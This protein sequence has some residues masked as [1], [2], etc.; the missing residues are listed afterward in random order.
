MA[1]HPYMGVI[2]IA[3]CSPLVSSLDV[4]EVLWLVDYTWFLVSIPSEIS[5]RRWVPVTTM[6][7]CLVFPLWRR[8][9]GMSS[10][11]FGSL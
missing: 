3:L 5:A 8:H 1:T 9:Q 11:K 7:S 4:G 6:L 2:F 10:S